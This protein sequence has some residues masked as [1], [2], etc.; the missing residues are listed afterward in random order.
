M[1]DRLDIVDDLLAHGANPDFA[2]ATGRTALTNAVDN[3][4]MEM[5]HHLLDHNATPKLVYKDV[6]SS[7]EEVLAWKSRS[8]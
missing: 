6:T 8:Q 1:F 4:N 3:G 7:L 5:V 2:A